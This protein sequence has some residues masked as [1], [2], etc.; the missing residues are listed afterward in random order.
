M[1]NK[2]ETKERDNKIIALLEI[3]IFIVSIMG[4]SFIYSDFNIDSNVNGN[5][6]NNLIKQSSDFFDLVPSVS[7]QGLDNLNDL[8]NVFNSAVSGLESGVGGCCFDIQEGLCSPNSNQQTCEAEE[9]GKFFSDTSCNVN[10]C[11]LG[12]CILGTEAQ[13]VTNQRC[14]K[15]SQSLGVPGEFKPEITNELSCIGLSN[16]Q[17]F[18]ACVY[19]ELSLEDKYNCKF[20]TKEDCNSNIGGNFHE[21]FICSNPDLNTA[22]EKQ[23]ITGCVD[24][25]D[26]IYWYDSCG[27][28]EN[29]Y[30][31]N[32]E[33]SWNNGQVLTKE[34]SCNPSSDNIKSTT[35]GNC[36]YNE[37][38]ICAQLRPGIDKKKKDGKYVCRDLNCR[39]GFK[40][41]QNGESWCLYDG[42]VGNGRDVVGSR[43]FRQLCVN[44]EIKTEPCADYRKEICVKEGGI[45]GVFQDKTQ[46]ILGQFG[47]IIPDL[48]SIPG[49]SGLGNIPGLSGIGGGLGLSPDE[50][51]SNTSNSSEVSNE[52]NAR[53]DLFNQDSGGSVVDKF[54]SLTDQKALCRPN[55]W[56]DCFSTN[57]AT[58]STNPDCKLKVVYVDTKFWFI[59]C[60][61]QYPAGSDLS[62]NNALSSGVSSLTSQLGSSL[63]GGDFAGAS[64]YLG[65]G[66]GSGGSGG[67]CSSGTKTCTVTYK[68]QCP[69]GKWECEKNCNCEKMQFTAQL[70][71]ACTMLGDCGAKA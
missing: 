42:I 68:K 34:E 71:D 49:L 66:I 69:S 35:C 2:K 63:G 26:E 45:G 24:G 57:V 29:I 8:S 27:N 52:I 9:N 61:P 32:K 4:F 18:G 39:D 67:S 53:N 59:K 6:E 33:R 50:N 70:N 31:S 64:N 44:G 12:C 16:S 25:K 11:N 46:E 38:S 40:I 19:G 37:G 65:G 43:H 14:L 30:D 47:A 62:N 54:N 20:T 7:A 23:K 3:T 58:C 41:K 10:E 36:A 5:F 1:E 60:V 56:E 13:L 22:C 28:R 48:S 21:G 55:M 17:S 51:N 15:L